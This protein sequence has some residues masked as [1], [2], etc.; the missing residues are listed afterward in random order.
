MRERGRWAKI[1]PSPCR[2]TGRAQKRSIFCPPLPHSVPV[3]PPIPIEMQVHKP[4]KC[5]AS[6]LPW[7]NYEKS[8]K[9]KFSLNGGWPSNWKGWP[10]I[11]RTSD[12]G[13]FRDKRTNGSGWLSRWTLPSERSSLR[14]VRLIWWGFFHC[15][16]LSLPSPVLGPHAQWV[17]HS[18]PS[19]LQ[20]LR[21]P[22]RLALTSSPAHRVSTLPP[23]PPASDIPAAGTPVGQPFFALTL[24]LK[25]KKWDCSPSSTSEGQSS[26]R[27]HAG[28]K[29]GS[30]SSGCSTPPIQPVANHSPNNQSLS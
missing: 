5:S 6:A 29:E 9:P 17:K 8:P 26:K 15:F 1:L 16:S 19:L 3:I 23:G 22:L 28:T 18:L 27:A 7:G 14:C 11:M 4:K 10:R 30:I 20:N 21:A 24:G 2:D 13:W 12:S 25:H